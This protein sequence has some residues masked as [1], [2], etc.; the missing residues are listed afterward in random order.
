M[1]IELPP[2]FNPETGMIAREVDGKQYH[3]PIPAVVLAYNLL[4]SGTPEDLTQA[5]RTLRAVISCQE[6]RS[7]D[8][9]LGNFLWE[10]EDEAVEDLN[11]AMTDAFRQNS[12]SLRD[13]IKDIKTKIPED[14]IT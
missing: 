3:A 12:A 7:G 10:R 9:H 2:G 5:E 8:P 14:L 1:P 13:E 6:T 11:A 4:E